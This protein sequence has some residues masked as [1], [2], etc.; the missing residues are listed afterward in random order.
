MTYFWIDIAIV[1]IIILFGVIGLFK[2]FFSTL[3]SLLG[4]VGTFIVAYLFCDDLLYLAEKLFKLET[5]IK[6]ILGDSIGHVV[7]I[8]LSLI[9]TYLI[10][11]LLVFILNHTIGKLFTKT[12][13]LKSFNSI[14]GFFLGLAR[15]A[16]FVA[17]IA[18]IVKII[19]LIPDVSTSIADILS[20]TYIADD[21]FK[22]IND[23]V[24]NF[25]ATSSTVE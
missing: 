21:I 9:I 5:W 13:V 12:P 14:L 15:G 11:K 17:I 22:W 2:G 18:I 19:C 6:G 25:F 1:G 24:G 16:I 7:A 3:L 4:I 8:V 20:K 23:F 10:I